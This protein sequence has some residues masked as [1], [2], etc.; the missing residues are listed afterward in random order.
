V[1][2]LSIDLKFLFDVV[3]AFENVYT[4]GNIYDWMS[5]GYCEGFFMV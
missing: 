3:L 4:F 1:D 5:I 2:Y